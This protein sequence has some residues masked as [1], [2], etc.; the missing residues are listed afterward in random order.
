[1]RFLHGIHQ[2]RYKRPTTRI[3]ISKTDLDAAYRRLHVWAQMALL[4]ITV[5]KNIAYILLR[6][7]FGVANGPNDYSLVSEPIMDLTNEI[8]LDESWDPSNVHSPLQSQLA[9]PHHRFPA[10]TPF[11]QARALFVPT[12]FCEAVTKVSVLT[13]TDGLHLEK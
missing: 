1:M 4:A 2:M 9:E 3:F 6:S 8:L 5:I 7:P 10:D 11:G 13:K 12:P